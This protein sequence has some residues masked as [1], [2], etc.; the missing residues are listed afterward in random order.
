MAT[1]KQKK[2]LHSYI[3]KNKDYLLDMLRRFVRLPSLEG[4]EAPMQQAVVDELNKM[5]ASL[6]LDVF[7]PDITLLK[8]HPAYVP[9]ELDYAGRPNVVATRRGAGGG[10]S[11]IL[12]GH[13]DVVPTGRDE[14][15]K[16]KTPWSGAYEDGRVYGRGACDMKA[17]LAVNIFM[18]KM[19]NELGLST[20]GDLTVESVVDEETGG[21]GTLAC[22]LRGY[23]ADGMIYTEPSGLEEINI[24]NRG[25]QYFRIIV[26]GQEGGTEYAHEL[27]NPID[28]A[29]ELM[30]AVRAYSIYREAAASH[31]LY[32]GFHSTKVPLAIAK[33]RAGE[34][35]STIAGECVMEGTIECLPGEDIHEVKEA[36]RQYLVKWCEKDSW[37]KEHP[38][39][40]E[41]FGLW[42]EAADQDPQAPFIQAFKSSASGYRGKNLPLVGAGGCDLRISILYGDTPSIMFGPSGGL[43]HSTDEYVEFFEVV[44]CAHIL[45][46]FIADWC[47]LAEETA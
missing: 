17:G 24:S 37:L 4:D 19:L 41:W 15:W 16:H 12:N 14:L 45:A 8:A 11:L 10:K 22:V 7:E 29:F 13:V 32:D 27:I 6:T 26:E 38:I 40:L 35:P 2:L 46:E 30:Q 47:G 34:W 42:F 31:P 21:N 1:E 43:I 39:R 3:D 18:L 25:A 36:F 20:L 9:V 44:E 33:I 5:G 23:R 28:K